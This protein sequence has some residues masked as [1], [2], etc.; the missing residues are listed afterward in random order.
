[1]K[2]A[3][4][5]ML[6]VVL[7]VAAV[8]DVEAGCHRRRARRGSCNTCAPQ[9]CNT[10]SPQG[11][12]AMYPPTQ[13]QPQPFGPQGQPAFQGAAPQVGPPTAAPSLPSGNAPP[14]PVNADL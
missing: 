8:T 3:I 1:M 6:F 5:A 7:T 2:R 12:Q 13:G 14:S 10:C 9:A 4:A 11:Y